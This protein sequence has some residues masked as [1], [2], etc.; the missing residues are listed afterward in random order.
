MQLQRYGIRAAALLVTLAALMF[1]AASGLAQDATG[2][3][4]QPT[5]KIDF[6]VIGFATDS[7]TAEQLKQVAAAAG[8]VYFDAQNQ[9]DL[10]S[11][12]SQ[13]VG[14]QAAAQTFTQEQE[15]NN[16]FGQANLI[17]ATSSVQGAILP[18]GDGDLYVLEVT[19]QGELKVAVDNVPANLDINLRL[20][21]ANLEWTDGW[22]GPLAKGGETSASIDLPSAG[23]YYLELRDGSDDEESA[24]AYTLKTTFSPTVDDLE[25]N[26]AVGAATSLPVN[27]TVQAT[28]L[29]KRDGDWVHLQVD[30]QGQ[31]DLALTN[32]ASDLDLVFR[33]YNA[34]LEWTDGWFYP[35][36][37][38]G[39]TKASVD[40]PAAGHYYVEVRDNN[41]DSRAL[42]PYL[43]RTVFTATVDNLEP[44]N[45]IGS[46][47]PIQSGQP[48][49][50]TILPKND[51]DWYSLEVAH[52]G[53]LTVKISDPPANLDMV[54]RVFNANG[55]WSDGWFRP[56]AVGGVTEAV[57]DLPRPG[58]YYLEVRDNDN[59]ER[60][61]LPYTLTAT[62]AATA[63]AFEPNDLFG[64]ATPLALGQS[65]QG[66]ILPKNDGDWYAVSVS[67]PGTL[68]VS[69]GAVA[70][71]LDIV[72]RIYNANG[73]WIQGWFNPLAKGGDT[74]AAMLLPDAG[75]YLIE[76]RDGNNDER[77]LQPYMLTV[78]H[79]P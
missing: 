78:S 13:G 68:T 64:A 32:V 44:N 34:N 37:K 11:A 77:A 51:G 41:D 79:T 15:E 65:V 19:H 7:A 39:D 55:E 75:R 46:A 28:I 70:P 42:Q 72:F 62:F 2:A 69:I 27:S 25:P 50:A 21:N 36:A 31:L 20:F 23:R 12:M 61:V 56:L 52:Q 30:H 58:R 8:G 49:Q 4:Q 5:L 33:V 14:V 40:L 73:E 47:S 54:F 16:R 6:Y 45:A 57:V 43:L 60:S 3:A 24:D 18:R 38:G 59:N 76:V 63:D 1:C 53:E 35:L 17:A 22:F 67:T 9:Q 66:T 29:P 71:N 26:N 10:E 74:Q 48:L